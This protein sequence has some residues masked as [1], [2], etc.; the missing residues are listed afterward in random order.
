MSVDEPLRA[1][2]CNNLATQRSCEAG[3]G[4]GPRALGFLRLNAMEQD[5]TFVFRS[6]AFLTLQ[7]LWMTLF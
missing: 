1:W 5:R 2:V 4:P 7:F 3:E 6:G